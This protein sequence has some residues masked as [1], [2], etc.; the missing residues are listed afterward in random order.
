MLKV[1]WSCH[2]TLAASFEDFYF[3]PNSI[4]KVIKIVGNWLSDKNSYRQKAKLRV[5]NISPPVLMGLSE[6]PG[7]A[8]TKIIY[9]DLHPIFL[10]K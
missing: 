9:G 2:V 6:I 1:I 4:G 8:L 10:G 5:E 7:D 3:S